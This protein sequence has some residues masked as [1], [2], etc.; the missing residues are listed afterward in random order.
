MS[1]TPQVGDV[2]LIRGRSRRH[3]VT[4]WLWET[5]W[6]HMAV[7]SGRGQVVELGWFGEPAKR[8]ISKYWEKQVVVL[9]P[10]WLTKKEKMRLAVKVRTYPVESRFDWLGVLTQM[11]RLP[12]I[13]TKNRV[14][15]DE[16]V[17]QIYRNAELEVDMY[18][19]M[20]DDL[21]WDSRSDAL[22]D[23]ALKKVFDWRDDGNFHP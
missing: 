17:G 23:F 11:L 15:C 9:R 4:R 10:L 19:L 13:R 2:L 7:Y 16:F 22:G 18:E 21:T 1:Y 3:I 6:N 8:N 12:R 20:C 5:K 14:R